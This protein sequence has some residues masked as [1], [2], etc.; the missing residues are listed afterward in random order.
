MS[1][2]EVIRL[3]Q[4]QYIKIYEYFYKWFYCFG[5]ARLVR[6]GGINGLEMVGIRMVSN[7]IGRMFIL[8]LSLSRLVLK[9]QKN[10]KFSLYY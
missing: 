8:F 5:H 7:K 1:N 3:S 6:F 4:S 9:Q 2:Y 10:N